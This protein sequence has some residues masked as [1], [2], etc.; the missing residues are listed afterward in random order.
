MDQLLDELKRVGFSQY[1]ARAYV[2]LLQRAP[3]TGYELS[4]RS[5]VP[6]SMIYEV[7]GKLLDRGAAYAVPAEPITYAPVP[8]GELVERLKREAEETFGY[9]EGALGSLERPREVDT[10]KRTRG[11]GPVSAELAAIVEGAREE[12]WLSLWGAQIPALADA[13]ERAEARGVRV[14]SVLFEEGEGTR[15]GRTFHHDY[16]PPEVLEHRLGGRLHIAARDAEEVVI[17][18]FVEG[19][20]PWALRTRD[21]ALVLVATEYV[22]HDISTDV[23]LRAHGRERLD[24]LW[25]HDPDLVQ[26]WTGRRP[27]EQDAG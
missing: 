27:E 1:E 12:L 22:R 5:G 17:A 21:P 20:V 10:I 3:V 13:V 26:V 7:L 19:S 16:T 8:A 15:L 2:A 23:V 18:Q 4:K 24:A 14:F 25:K 9:L 11:R 6:R